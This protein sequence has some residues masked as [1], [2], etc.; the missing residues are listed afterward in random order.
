MKR[1]LQ[2][3]LE[4]RGV[5][6]GPDNWSGL[7]DYIVKNFNPDKTG[8]FH[9]DRKYLPPWMGDCIIVIKQWCS[10]GIAA[11][12][13]DE[14]A[15]IGNVM[16]ICIEVTP[17]ALRTPAKFHTTLEHELQHAY[18]DYL[19]RTRR[20]RTTFLDDDYC[21]AIGYEGPNFEDLNHWEILT[22]P[23]KCYFDHAFY[24][25]RESTYWF[26][27]TEIN[28]YL[29]EFS[30]Y[31]KGL[32]ASGRPFDWVKVLQDEEGVNVIIPLTGML[33]IYT[34]YNNIN[35]YTGIE[36]DYVMDCINERWAP[37]VLGHT[38]KGNNAV[39]FRKVLEELIKK[40]IRKPMER[41]IR[42]VKD[43]GVEMINTPEWFK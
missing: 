32:A 30:M 6:T 41:Y 3:I 15:L 42:V 38:V 18:D 26:A 34:M 9:C 2:Y 11:Y 28:A 24:V 17:K 31:L 37:M 4:A 13:S 35:K 20:G 21:V 7:V 22:D 25:L 27:P 16:D 5:V 33:L 23:V 39:A 19:G 29:R 40:K 8:E 36:W 10:G 12:V 1:L 14:S 43:S